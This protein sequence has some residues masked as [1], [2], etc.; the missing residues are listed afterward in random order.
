MYDFD[1]LHPRLGLNSSKWDTAMEEGC[2]AD[3]VPLT[4][5]DMEFK[6]APVVVEA[7]AKTAAF[8]L[9]GYTYD[10]DDF[11]AA[12]RAWMEKR[13]GW[14]AEPAWMVHTSGVVHGLY[15]AVRA[16]TSAGDNVLVQPPVYHPFFSAVT[17]TGR[18]LIEN[19][20]R[21][22]DGR[23]EIDFEDLRLKL[24]NANMMIFCSPHNPVGRVWRPEE[25]QKVAR[26]C[27]EAGVPLFS[28]EIHCDLIMEGS[29]HHSAGHLAGDLL[30]NTIIATSAS[31]TFSMAGL[32]CATLLVP[33]FAMR[34]KIKDRLKRDGY[35]FSNIFGV[36]GTRTAYNAG[37][38]WLDELLVYVKENYNFLHRQLAQKLPMIRLCPMEGTYLAW[39]D[40]SAL[41]LSGDDQRD[42]L[43][44]DALLYVNDG[45]VFGE[46]GNGFAR[47]NLACPRSVLQGAVGRLV[48]AVE[49]RGFIFN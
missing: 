40:F 36:A 13:H 26:L 7:L 47:M 4:I 45:R 33:S 29:K 38:D 6:T 24:N 48:K 16:L 32:A 12:I 5:A 14:A 3:I 9:W 2:P 28:D 15:A 35:F 23:Y 8:G 21:C 39:L 11:K 25:V 44:K 34:E 18:Y 43:E 31:K 27:L 49:K 1:T 46:G 42:F 10:G 19:P 37:A 17:D 22:I 20:L 30:T 41:R